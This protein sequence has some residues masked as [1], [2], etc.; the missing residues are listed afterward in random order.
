[1]NK[2]RQKI[3]IYFKHIKSCPEEW[4]LDDWLNDKNIIVTEEYYE[5]TKQ[6]WPADSDLTLNTFKFSNTLTD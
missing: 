1:M 6:I 2:S 5:K 3:K 4:K